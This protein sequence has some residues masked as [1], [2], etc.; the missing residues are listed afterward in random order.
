M[1]S[2]IL[3]VDDEPNT[4]GWMTHV[5][6]FGGYEV[7]TAENGETALSK[8]ETEQ[9]DLMILDVRLADTDGIEVCQR[10]RGKPQTADLP[11]IMLSAL[12]QVADRVKGLRAGA[13]DYVTKPVAVE[14][15]LARV[16]TLLLRAARLSASTARAKML[17]LVGAKGG[18]GTTTV[19]VNLALA[20]VQ[21]GK[22]VILVDLHPCMGCVCR[23]LGLDLCRGWTELAQ[24][25][26]RGIRRGDIERRLA[27][28]S[29]GL[30]VLGSDEVPPEPQQRELTSSQAEA[31]LDELS[32][33]AEWV[34]FDLP[35]QFHPA[36]ES[37]LGRCDLMTVV[38]EADPLALRRAKDR[39]ALLQQRGIPRDRAGVVIVNRTQSTM[40]MPIGELEDRLGAAVVGVMP[41]AAEACLHALSHGTP[42]ILARPD[43]LAAEMLHDMVQRLV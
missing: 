30:Q 3:I 20:L 42:L 33:M 40:T 8:A 4:I 29:T 22:S 23:M 7:I 43:H 28:H 11:I 9:P 2:K 14:E 25:E 31:M 13:D 10:L 38:T 6:E 26:S 21:H 15:L 36:S 39:L 18:V 12:A 37:V 27:R 16:E 19:A 17:A 5:L 35:V 41:P 34:I 24:I 32:T 1:G